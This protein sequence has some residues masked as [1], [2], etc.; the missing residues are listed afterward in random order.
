MTSPEEMVL[1]PRERLEI[2]TSAATAQA[3]MMQLRQRMP[4]SSLPSVRV[5]I[6]GIE[7]PITE[8]VMRAE[9]EALVKAVIEQRTAL[10]WRKQL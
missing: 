3:T 8:E 10:G 7:Q 1:V 4:A 5:V 2:L 6:D 9:T